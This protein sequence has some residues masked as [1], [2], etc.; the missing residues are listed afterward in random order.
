MKINV[1][2]S[3]MRSVLPGR[4][5]VGSVHPIITTIKLGHSVHEITKKDLFFDSGSCVLLLKDFPMKVSAGDLGTFVLQ[6]EDLAQIAGFSVVEHVSHPYAIGSNRVWSIVEP[7]ERFLVIGY[8][9]EFDVKNKV[10][11]FLG[12]GVCFSNVLKVF[13]ESASVFYKVK[14]FD[15]SG[16]EVV[17]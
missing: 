5:L 4:R 13:S 10:G 3:K 2:V 17:C 6:D 9:S 15:R 1:R 8:G 14:I 11:F 16:E 7:D 12:S